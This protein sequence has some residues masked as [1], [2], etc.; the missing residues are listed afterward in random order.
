MSKDEIKGHYINEILKTKDKIRKD[1][2]KGRELILKSKSDTPLRTRIE[3][4][5][6]FSD[7]YFESNRFLDVL[8]NEIKHR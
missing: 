4:Y 5:K 7:E 6:Q 8:L 2:D 1:F 3:Q